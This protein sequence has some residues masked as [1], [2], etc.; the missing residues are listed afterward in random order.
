MPETRHFYFAETRHLHF[1]PTCFEFAVYFA[2]AQFEITTEPFDALATSLRQLVRHRVQ[3]I[4]KLLV[5]LVEEFRL[6]NH[7]LPFL[8][9]LQLVRRSN[10]CQHLEFPLEQELI[11]VMHHV[12]HYL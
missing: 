8:L 7:L 9:Q 1:A 12:P 11:D 3:A 2:Y 5:F 6:H 4:V 10:D